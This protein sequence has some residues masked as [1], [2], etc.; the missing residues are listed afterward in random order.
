METSVR[1]GSLRGWTELVTQLGGE[2]SALLEDAGLPPDALV[3]EDALISA[4]AAMHLL[5]RAAGDLECPDFALQL[6]HYQ[7]ID[8]FGPLTAALRN[9]PTVRAFWILASQWLFIHS[10]AV[11]LSVEEADG[12]AAILFDLV[13]DP[14]PPVRQTIDL[15]LATCHRLFAIVLGGVYRPVSVWVPHTPSAPLTRYIQFFAATVHPESRRAQIVVPAWF[16]DARIPDADDDIRANALTYIESRFPLPDATLTERVRHRVFRTLG[17]EDADYGAVAKSLSLHPRTM[18]RHLGREGT[19]FAG[20]K[21]DVMRNTAHRYLIESTM[22]A[23]QLAQTLGF[24][25]L[26][27]FTRACTRWFGASPTAVRNRY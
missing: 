21:D 1:P 27:A 12:S 13:L 4:R 7:D 15:V 25:E 20:I 18:Q 22:P 24:S 5:E 14:L 11:T 10:P 26:S 3:D 6:S 2:P 17:T 9:A 8:A 19:S 23:S 16:L